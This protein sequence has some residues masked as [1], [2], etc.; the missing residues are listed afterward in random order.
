MEG[1]SS[2]DEDG[3]GSCNSGRGRLY[4]GTDSNDRIS[5]GHFDPACRDSAEALDDLFDQSQHGYAQGS[6]AQS[7]NV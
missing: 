5:R 7:G 6:C 3:C 4:Y 2:L 1:L